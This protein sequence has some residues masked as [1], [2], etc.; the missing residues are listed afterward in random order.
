MG[1][2]FLF[3]VKGHGKPIA[4]T[5]VNESR[6]IESI[7]EE[8]AEL[9]N[10]TEYCQFSTENDGIV[11]KPGEVIAVYISDLNGTSVKSSITSNKTNLEDEINRIT[12]SSKILDDDSYEFEEEIEESFDTA[13]SKSIDDSDDIPDEVLDI[14]DKSSEV[15]ESV[16][17][18]KRTESAKKKANPPVTRQ[19]L[20]G[21][22]VIEVDESLNTQSDD[23]ATNVPGVSGVHIR[24]VVLKK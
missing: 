11:I 8:I 3:Y 12:K 6:N 7:S 2:R 19:V 10:S 20:N 1:K 5:D 16:T 22:V 21:G 13:Y 17:T 4:I 14:F 9:M 18:A 15:P 24:P 23:Q